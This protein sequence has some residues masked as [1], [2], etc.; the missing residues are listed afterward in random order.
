MVAHDLYA[1]TNP[2]FGT[3]AIV[4]FCR[5]YQLASTRNPSIALLY[6]AL[7][8]AMSR[9]VERSFSETNAKTGLLAWLNRYPELRLNLGARLDA[10]LDVVTASLRLGLMSNALELLEKGAIGLGSKPPIKA[11]IT[12]LPTEP[13]KAIKR[14]ERLGRWMGK[15]GSPGSVF[16][17]FGVI[18]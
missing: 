4:A 18:L 13:K 6:L 5:E 14:A 12:R 3:Y 1:E 8:I 2:A 10:S 16:S 9:D 15:A 7:P 11:P 17:A